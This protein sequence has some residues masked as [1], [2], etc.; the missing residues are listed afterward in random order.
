MELI[1]ATKLQAGYTTGID[2]DG[3]ERVIVAIKGTFTI[4]TDGSEPRLADE[5]V[6]LVLA[7]EFTG[8]PGLSAT[9]YECDYA[10]AKPYCDVLLN[11][12][13]YAPGGR[14]V[15][16]VA[17]EFSFAG[18]SKCFYV[19][20]ARV[21]E[22]GLLFIKSS[23]PEPFISKA[24]TYDGAFGGSDTHPNK[25]EKSKA[26]QANPIGTG[27]YPMSR[28]EA[29]I[30]KALPSTSE[31]SRPI[32]R[33]SGKFKPMSLGPIGRAIPPRVSFAGTYDDDWLENTFPFLPPDFDTRYF[34]CAP[35]D[36]QFPYPKGGEE[37][38][39][40]NLTPQ[41]RT[42]FCLPT[43]NLPVEFT[44]TKDKRTEQTAVLDTVLIEPD[45]GRFMLTWRAS[46]PLR[47]NIMEMRECVIG[48]MSPGWYH[49]RASGKP[50]YP[51]LN[52]VAAA[53]RSPEGDE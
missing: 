44:D 5:Q 29:L 2:P 33:R 20:G 13:A 7:D 11:G 41:G 48:R 23:E 22:R 51:S 19:H 28:G 36:Q 37:V 6:E 50:Y 42:A 35:L 9:I 26:F 34:Q 10:P 3:R 15:E 4:P 49:A 52:A 8:E 14:P 12:S 32:T 1:N 38:L 47:R 25:P 27:Y 46:L 18:R 45:L 53:N 30:G 21:W 43:I 17:V 24:I 39:L 16:K 40:I 31:T